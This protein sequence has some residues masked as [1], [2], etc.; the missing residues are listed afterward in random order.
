MAKDEGDNGTRTGVGGSLFDKTRT[1]LHNKT[2]QIRMA[3][4]KVYGPYSRP[5]V[6]SFILGKKLTGEEEIL[7]EGETDWKPISSDIEFFD[8]LQ[9]VLMN[10][11]SVNSEKSKK[12]IT[13]IAPT[14]VIP[15]R[16][17]KTNQNT[18]RST[19]PTK[20]VTE[21]K[22]SAVASA[23]LAA[24]ENKNP[25]QKTLAT[26]NFGFPTPKIPQGG[27][28]KTKNK[29]KTLFLSLATAGLV[30]VLFIFQN[31]GPVNTKVGINLKSGFFSSDLLYSKILKNAL[32]DLKIDLTFE[33]PKTL[34]RV[35]EFRLPMGFSAEVWA[36]QIKELLDSGD[37]SERLGV[38]YWGKM[39]W[40]LILLGSAID[41]FD[42]RLGDEI[43]NQGIRIFEHLK[44]TG[45]LD[46]EKIS[47]FES[48]IFLSQGDLN[49]AWD[50]TES[51]KGS[52]D[53]AVV[54]YVEEVSWTYFWANGAKGEI[55]VSG[56]I[57]NFD[58]SF[59]DS[60]A[61]LRRAFVKKDT[62]RF[63][64]WVI[65]TANNHPTMP[66]LW[67]STAQANWRFRGDGALL[68][69]KLFLLSLSTASLLPRPMQKV[70]WSEFVGFT[71]TFGRYSVAKK[72]AGNL[73]ILESGKLGSP[74]GQKQWIDLGAS[75][76]N[77]GAV[78]EEIRR[79]ALSGPLGPREIASLAVIGTVLPN[80]ESYFLLAGH[81]AAFENQWERAED[82]FKRLVGLEPQSVDGWGGLVWAYSGR[83]AFDQAF[84][85]HD[86]IVLVSKNLGSKRVNNEVEKY[87]GLLQKMGR[88]YVESEK[89]LL[90][91]VRKAPNDGWS[92]YFLAQLYSEQG[93]NIPCI[94]SA[95]LGR[96]HGTGELGFRSELLFY[97]CRIRGRVDV[98]GALAD[99]KRRLKDSPENLPLIVALGRGL[100]D[101]DL[102]AE[103]IKFIG[104]KVLQFPRSFE[105]R[106]LLG[107]LYL[108]Q[109]DLD[110][111]VLFFTR[112][113]QD[114]KTSAEPFMRI[115]KIFFDQERYLEAARN[116]EGAAIREPAYPEAW[117]WAA[118]AYE[119]A[120]K[121]APAMQ[122]YMKE[123]D[124]RP[125]VLATFLEASEF[126]LS[127]N[128][129]QEVPK[130][131]QKFAATFQDDPRVLTRL[132][133]AY[134][135]L[136]DYDNAQRM[137]QTALAANP[138]LAEPY[139]VLGYVF[140]N[141]AQY[142]SAK[143][144]F[145]KYLQL[146]PQA[147]DADQ[148]QLKLSQ[149]PY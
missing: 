32:G 6:V 92:H 141:Q 134:L 81:N 23:P 40:S 149:P 100:S 50:R 136:Q 60:A 5:E 14:A 85:A 131:F 52:Q 25:V 117:L 12:E 91:S 80:P 1:H 121:A 124:E 56:K 45:S 51:I 99:L 120:G 48:A 103:A 145:E 127:I 128:A 47:A 58:D 33:I 109:K 97:A 16:K 142:E 75:E 27:S 71:E 106:M 76:L 22:R 30:F 59:A 13:K 63:N 53:P 49:K 67:F 123:I 10:R 68:A 62:K 129:P 31:L 55:F 4:K 66:L 89:T 132:S 64:E 115:G 21:T 96:V 88:E 114:R 34:S 87:L 95:N 11:E 86:K 54:S 36:Q 133:Q 24:N 110:R 3:S 18:A 138:N 143:R 105:L 73:Q 98:K 39:A 28:P 2:L 65:Q 26:P 43:S 20:K 148:I 69:N 130:L 41:V 83:F 139:R 104:D 144:Y 137:A 119:K 90:S 146:L 112:A 78:G 8:L 84:E 101:A 93:K 79:A 37:P 19:D 42:L 125:A 35:N 116:F 94:K 61:Q 108:Q 140:D 77:L 44:N 126:L 122:A 102:N 9:N 135:A 147:A 70:F 7:Y 118:R 111:A 82:F 72:I 29:S 46:S 15:S 74:E 57:E 113:S 107:D 17:E 38:P